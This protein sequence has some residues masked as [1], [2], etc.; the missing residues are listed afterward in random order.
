MGDHLLNEGL[1]RKKYFELCLFWLL[2]MND[3]SVNICLHVSIHVSVPM[4]AV[5]YAL[6]SIR[7]FDCVCLNSRFF[8]TSSPDLT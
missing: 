7:G 3:L 1:S 6:I 2:V 5:L 8:Q 4:C